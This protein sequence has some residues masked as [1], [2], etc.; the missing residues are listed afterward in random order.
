[1]C[2]PPETKNLTFSLGFFLILATKN[3]RKSRSIF[4]GNNS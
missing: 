3:D 1:M 4:Y 2:F